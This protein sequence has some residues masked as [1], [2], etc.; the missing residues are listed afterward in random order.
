LSGRTG[1]RGQRTPKRNTTPR[2]DMASGPLAVAD[3][4]SDDGEAGSFV[5]WADCVK[6]V[7]FLLF[8]LTLAHKHSSHALPHM[9]NGVITCM[10]P[11]KLF[12]ICRMV[13]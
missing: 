5:S 11:H 9:H 8:Y 6:K 4:E 1:C 2:S 12:S 13:W 7:I 3:A 10:L